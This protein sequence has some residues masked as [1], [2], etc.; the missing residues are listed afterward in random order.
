M[1]HC[2]CVIGATLLAPICIILIILLCFFIV[3]VADLMGSYV[4]IVIYSIPVILI[5]CVWLLLY[6]H[7]VEY[8]AKREGAE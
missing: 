3:W 4:L 6:W 2:K 5:A 7:C 1:K 8:W